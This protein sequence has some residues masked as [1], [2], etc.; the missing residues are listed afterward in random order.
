MLASVK[1]AGVSDGL[2]TETPPSVCKVKAAQRSPLSKYWF[3]EFAKRKT[4][5]RMSMHEF[6]KLRER[7]VGIK[8]ENNRWY[9]AVKLQREL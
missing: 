4:R 9:N 8:T 3:V 5:T 6:I 2:V 7:D 1:T